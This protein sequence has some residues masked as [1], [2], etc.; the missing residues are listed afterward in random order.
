MS[1]INLF[2]VTNDHMAQDHT[3]AHNK[4]CN[5]HMTPAHLDLPITDAGEKKDELKV[6][7]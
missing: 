6:Q 3:K 4:T 2:V 1:H 7:E 5:G